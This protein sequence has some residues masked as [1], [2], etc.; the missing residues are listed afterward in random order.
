MSHPVVVVR[1]R[2]PFAAFALVLLCLCFGSTQY[3]DEVPEVRQLVT[4]KFE[5]GMTSRAVRIFVDALLPVYKDA[6]ALVRFR[7]YHEAESPEPLDLIVVSSFKGMAGMDALNAQLARAR[8]AGPSVRA[9]Y[10][11]IAD[12][13]AFHHDQFVEMIGELAVA[14]APSHLQVFESVRIVPGG[15]GDFERLLASTVVP[16]ERGLA[17]IK[18]SET[19]RFL[20]SDGWD[21]LRILGIDSLA[22]DYAYVSAARTQAFAAR[23]DGLVVARKRIVLR[24]DPALS[25][26]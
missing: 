17:S 21:Y 9:L 26:R 16:W 10:G 13:S 2:S 7:G 8:P 14:K 11:Q 5:A 1:M 15:R 25:V 22:D 24:G 4:F 6:S 19:G 3:A 18:T 20:I 12:M 23:L